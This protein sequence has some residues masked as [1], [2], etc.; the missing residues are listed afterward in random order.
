M[1][2]RTIRFR[3]E[4]REFVMAGDLPLR[5]G[6]LKEM[7]EGDAGSHRGAGKLPI[8]DMLRVKPLSGR[9][10]ELDLGHVEWV[11]GTL[12]YLF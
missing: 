2:L 7:S 1:K 3:A 11:C 5:K 4:E 6:K 12:G 10:K 9:R 8:P